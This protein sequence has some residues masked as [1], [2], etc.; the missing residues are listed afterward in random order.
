MEHLLHRA[1]VLDAREG[2][3]DETNVVFA[4]TKLIFL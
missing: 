2:M 1:A 4:H 3:V